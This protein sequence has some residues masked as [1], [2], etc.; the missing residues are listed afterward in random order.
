MAAL[1]R[2]NERFGLTHRAKE[3]RAFIVRYIAVEGVAPSYREMADGVGLA[4]INGV[5]RLIREL[6]ERGHIVTLKRRARSL[7]IVGDE[8]NVVGPVCHHCGFP[9]N[10]DA[11]RDAA[12]RNTTRFFQR[13][14]RT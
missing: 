10:S 5:S 14:A 13:G 8:S 7:Q 3:L 12:S 9:F 6:E 2:N 11:C 4:S 1:A